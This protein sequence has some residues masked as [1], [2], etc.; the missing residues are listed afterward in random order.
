MGEA[1]CL[2]AAMLWAVAISIFRRPIQSHGAPVVNLLKCSIAT[3]LLGATVLAAGQGA[4]FADAS[5]WHLSMIAVSAWVGLTLGD[6]FL[7]TAIGRI[8]P[9]RAVLLQT[10]APMF[11]AALALVWLGETPTLNQA[12]GAVVVLLA[13]ALVLRPSRRDRRVRLTRRQLLTGVAFGALGAMGQGFGI[14]FAKEGMAEVPFLAAAFL[15]MVAATFG[16]LLLTARGGALRALAVMRTREGARVTGASFLG[17]YLAIGLMMAGVFYA[18][19][20][21]AAVLLATVPLF[22]MFVDAATVGEPITVRGIV[23]TLAAVLGVL[24]LSF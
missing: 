7:F 17:S 22:A 6:T 13:I 20:A 24:V 3:V 10:L 21:V 9:Y 2:C 18:P 4:V 19:A 11:T 15:R 12:A 14:V 23:G 5:A 8:G 1:A 16:L